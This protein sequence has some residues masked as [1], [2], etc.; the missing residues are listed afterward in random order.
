MGK[1][2]ARDRA[3]GAPRTT[4]A[5]RRSSSSADIVNAANA[6]VKDHPSPLRPPTGEPPQPSGTAARGT[7]HRLVFEAKVGRHDVFDLIL[8]QDVCR[9]LPS[10][11]YQGGRMH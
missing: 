4:S 9:V 8:S 11:V 2:Q 10:F 5:M 6:E 3:K 7:R 1:S